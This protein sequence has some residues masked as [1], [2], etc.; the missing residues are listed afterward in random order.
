M[1]FK[2][3]FN[4]ISYYFKDCYGID[5]LTQYMVIT[6]LILGIFRYVQFLGAALIIIGLYRSLSKNK[7]KRSKELASFENFLQIIKQQ[8]YSRMANF[9]EAKKFKIVKCPK[10][11]QKLRIPRN[12]GK[13]I[14]TCKKCGNE[15]K[16]KS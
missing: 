8:F 2:N 9:K 3:L 15:F 7:Y 16:A 1:D 12:K 4:K 14:V 5:K 11:S 6:G 13:I 10:C